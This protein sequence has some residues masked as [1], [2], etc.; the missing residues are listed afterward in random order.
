LAKRAAVA[1]QTIVVGGQTLV[2]VVDAVNSI[3]TETTQVVNTVTVTE[4]SNSFICKYLMLTYHIVYYEP[5][6]TLFFKKKTYRQ[7]LW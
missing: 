1:T 3:V 2:Q 4:T 6:L 7:L 5:F